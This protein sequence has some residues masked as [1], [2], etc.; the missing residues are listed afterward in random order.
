MS[1]YCHQNIVDALMK[2]TVDQ[3][4]KNIEYDYKH[5]WEDEGK[6]YLDRFGDKPGEKENTITPFGMSAAWYIVRVQLLEVES[7]LEVGCGFGRLIA[8]LA[9]NPGDK[10][11]RLCGLELSTTMIERSKEF[12]SKVPLK[13]PVDIFNGDARSLPFKDK[14]F[15]MI[16]TH[17]CLTHIPPE[18]MTEIHKE[19]DRVAK[20]Y[21]MLGERYVFPYE[22]PSPHRWTH[23]HIPDFLAMGWKVK[24][25]CLMHK[26]HYTTLLVLERK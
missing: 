4:Y 9:Q 16:Y 8:F 21:I 17:V 2:E 18:Y 12:L 13:I 22:H 1:K 3:D 7:A 23:D 25:Y 10:L 24:E 11:K 15:D 14:E 20:K 19:M 5:F 26:E 6:Y